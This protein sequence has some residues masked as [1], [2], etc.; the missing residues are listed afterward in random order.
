MDTLI[1]DLRYAARTLLKSPGFTLVAV[2]TLALGI[3]ANTAIFSVHYGVL[4]RPLPYPEPDRLVGLS[5]VYQGNRDERDVTYP[6]FTFL[7]DNTSSFESFA[8]STSVG[9]D[10][11]ASGGAERVDGLRVSK[12]YFRAL[13]VHPALGRDFAADEDVLGGPNV[14]ILSH[15]LWV[16]G[17]GSD[18]ALVGRAIS[19][20]G[21]PYTVVGVLPAGFRSPAPVDLYSTVAQVSRTIG[22][23]ENLHV[24]ARLRPGTTVAQ[25]QSAAG[26]AV[27]E[28]MRQFIPHAPTD[29]AIGFYPYRQLLVT[30]FR[31]PLGA[32]FVA[33]GLVL[34]I[35][36]ANV[37]NL[38]LSRAAA[39]TRELA[40]RVSLG[41]TRRRLARQLLTE[42]VLLGLVGG[43]AGLVVFLAA[44]GM[45]RLPGKQTETATFDLATV[46][47]RILADNYS[48]AGGPRSIGAAGMAAGGA[49]FWFSTAF[50]AGA[51]SSVSSSG[52]MSSLPMVSL[53]L[54]I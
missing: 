25:A 11:Y 46:P 40:V 20:E 41:A 37:A 22:G 52:G 13:G 29:F 42:S 8:V 24:I 10:V 30:G 47:V 5:E 18:P 49:G 6:E 23:G 38:V 16:R 32:L 31:T 1:Q 12:E 7:R 15:G 33:V 4:L 27:A 43:A 34:L 45:R 50:S 36:C 44:A 14:V 53:S 21:A 3:G 54:V 9:F 26:P 17:F 2:L 19:V 51:P 28:F 39:R 35:A 48:D